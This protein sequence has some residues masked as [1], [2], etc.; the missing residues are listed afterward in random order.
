MQKEYT[1][2]DTPMYQHPIKERV[3]DIFAKLK[4][5]DKLNLKANKRN[6]L[7]DF[8]SMVP[9]MTTNAVKRFHVI[10][11]FKKPDLIDKKYGR[12]PD[13]NLILATYRRNPL[14]ERY[15]LLQLVC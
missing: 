14:V 8:L 6:T 4:N 2:K 13:F 11:G 5:A 3:H 9:E 15:F 1:I 7:I 12:Y 10:K